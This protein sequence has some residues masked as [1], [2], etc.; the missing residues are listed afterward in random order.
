MSRC[1]SR[2]YLLSTH[3]TQ[4]MGWGL[5]FSHGSEGK[6]SPIL[7]CTREG[8]PHVTGE[9]LTSTSER[10]APFPTPTLGSMLSMP[11]G[12]QDQFSLQRREASTCFS[13][14]LPPTWQCGQGNGV[15]K[16]V[17]FSAGAEPTPSFLLPAMAFL[18]HRGASDCRHPPLPP[19]LW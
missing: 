3:C 19:R 17:G 9:N 18:W 6:E 1:G 4:G 16:W 15:G 12:A 2:M 14:V 8:V 10:P 7:S 13:A 5:L 11:S